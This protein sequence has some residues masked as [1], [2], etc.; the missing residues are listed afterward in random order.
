MHE[1]FHI[2]RQF[3]LIAVLQMLVGYLNDD[4]VVVP[5]SGPSQDCQLMATCDDKCNEHRGS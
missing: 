3:K 4:Y 1:G 2:S 5:C